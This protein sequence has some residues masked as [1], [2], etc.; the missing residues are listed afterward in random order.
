[1]RRIVLDRVQLRENEL[2][3]VSEG[4][5]TM[6]HTFPTPTDE[7]AFETFCMRLLQ[8]HWPNSDP[9]L[10]GR[11]GQRQD[12][13]DIIDESGIE[14]IFDAAARAYL[15][16]YPPEDAHP[17]LLLGTRQALDHQLG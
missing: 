2:M 1:M 13:V 10:Y 7:I 15:E 5:A 11:R 4:I 14:L 16:A 3:A 6:E 8:V 17:G 12:G 9:Q